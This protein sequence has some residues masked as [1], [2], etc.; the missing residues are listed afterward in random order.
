MRCSIRQI[1]EVKYPEQLE[2]LAK[3]GRSHIG[4]RLHNLYWEIWKRGCQAVTL[5]VWPHVVWDAE[6]DGYRCYSFCKNLVSFERLSECRYFPSKMPYCV[7]DGCQNA[8]G[9]K[10]AVPE[11]SFHTFPLT[12]KPCSEQKCIQTIQQSF[13]LRQYNAAFP[14]TSYFELFSNKHLTKCL[15][16]N[17]AIS[18]L[19]SYA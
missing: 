18:Y 15:S 8:R 6:L 5:F 2:M 9:G 12:D 16:T 4:F 11:V 3:R 14:P 7:V 1:N 10:H 13:V 19:E 17:T